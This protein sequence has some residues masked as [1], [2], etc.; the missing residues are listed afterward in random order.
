MKILLLGKDGQVGWELQRALSP[1]GELIAF[2]RSEADLEDTDSL[3]Q[4]IRNI[5]PAAIVNAAAYTAVDKAETESDLA[6]RV[7]ADAVGVLAEEAAKLD[8]RFVHYS[9]DYVFDGMK[10]DAYSEDDA[11]NPINVYG[12][13]KLAG[14]HLARQSGC[15]HLLFRTSWVYAARGRN[16]AKTILRLAEERDNLKVVAD[17]VGAP[18][19]AELIADITALCLYR[20]LSSG[21]DSGRLSGTYHLVAAGETSWHGYARYVIAKAIEKGASLKAYTDTI[22]PVTTSSY[23]LPTRRPLNSRLNTQKLKATFELNLPDW[24]VHVD[25]ML[26]ETIALG[27]R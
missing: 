22:E 17:Q 20:F 27:V 24:R 5:Q 7:N 25:R 13:T 14:E 26:D 18:T 6:Q 15:H 11:T 12:R 9:T 23:S 1:L 2:G 21:D 19:S 8:A 16:F 4:T 3:R 10:N